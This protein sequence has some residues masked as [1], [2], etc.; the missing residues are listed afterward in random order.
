MD[1]GYHQFTVE[2]ELWKFKKHLNAIETS[3]HTHN[4][5][6]S[7]LPW[8]FIRIRFQD[9][10]IDESERVSDVRIA[11]TQLKDMYNL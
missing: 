11:I 5:E 4:D 3:L 10:T 1:K 9:K 7:D 8:W 2:Q 6:T